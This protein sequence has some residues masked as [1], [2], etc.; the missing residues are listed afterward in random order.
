LV[1]E[2]NGKIFLAQG[3]DKFAPWYKNAQQNF[4]VEREALFYTVFM[5]HKK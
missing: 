3:K 1:L 5:K 2:S 4:A